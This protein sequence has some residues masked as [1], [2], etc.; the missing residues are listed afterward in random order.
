MVWGK[1]APNSQMQCSNKCDHWEDS[2]GINRKKRSKTVINA[3][4]QIIPVQL[5]HPLNH[6][7]QTEPAG[8]QIVFEQYGQWLEFTLAFLTTFYQNQGPP[9]TRGEYARLHVHSARR[10]AY[11]RNL[12]PRHQWPMNC[13]PILWASS[14][15]PFLPTAYFLHSSSQTHSNL[16]VTSNIFSNFRLKKKGETNQRGTTNITHKLHVLSG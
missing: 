11:A 4:L 1:S 13:F 7:P 15:C 16:S 14:S 6:N 3:L 9:P 10:T 8:S 2:P 5:I 12:S